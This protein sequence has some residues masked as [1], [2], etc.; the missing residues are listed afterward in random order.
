MNTLDKTV[1]SVGIVLLIIIGLAVFYIAGLGTGLYIAHASYSSAARPPTETVLAPTFT[2]SA[3]AAP[4]TPTLATPTPAATTQTVP[5]AT[6]SPSPADTATPLPSP[7]PTS[8]EADLGVFWEAWDILRRDFYGELPT[9]AELPY[10][11]IQG[12]IATTGDPYT[13]ILDPVQTEIFQTKLSGSFEGIGATVHLRPDGKLEIVYPLPGYPASQAGLRPKDVILQ[14]DGV[15][16]QGMNLYEAILLIRGPEGSVVRLLVERED[17][18]KPFEVEIERATIELPVVESRM[19]EE[20]IGYIRL[21][22]FG[23]TATSALREA[24]RE[25]NAQEPKG[26][27]LDL[28]GNPGGYLST[29]IEVTSQFVGQGPILIEQFKDGR[30]QRHQAIAGGLALDIPIVVLVNGGSAS[31]SEIAAG[32]IQDTERG[33]LIGVSTR[34][35]GS[36][37]V[38]HALSDGS[39]LRVTIAYW[40]TPNGRAIHG[41]GLTP[42][43]E[44]EM[45]E[46][47]FATGRD[48]QLDR[49]VTYLLEGE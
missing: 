27:I 24:L 43:I 29:A 5:T 25:L 20:G 4:V 47:D 21:T 22:E 6:S 32:A 15:D 14:V 11:A 16:I 9:E 46:Q 23:Q 12:V 8:G 30:E 36:V 7:T 17:L 42:D 41:E 34:G 26:L 19:L 35:K 48:P 3:T 18:D 49:A 39:Q 1:K 10:A 33:I 40:F 31:A 44:V 13:A 45:T 28:R 37:Q 38:A 2:P